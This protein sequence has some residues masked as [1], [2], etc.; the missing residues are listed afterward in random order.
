M[1]NINDFKSWIPIPNP[2][3]NLHNQ[4]KCPYCGRIIQLNDYRDG[5][6]YMFCPYCGK[7]LL[8]ISNKTPTKS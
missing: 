4:W 1:N 7:Q 5:C 8:A 6:T 3:G 2:F